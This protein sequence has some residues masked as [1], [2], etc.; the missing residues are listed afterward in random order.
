MNVVV[1]EDAESVE[2]RFCG[3]ELRVAEDGCGREGEGSV[4]EQAAD[5]KV[6]VEV[7][8]GNG[9]FLDAV[10][11][12]ERGGEIAGEEVDRGEDVVGVGVVGI[13][14]EGATEPA[15]CGGI[16]LLL[17]GDSGEFDGKT[18]LRWALAGAGQESGA[19]FNEAV[20]VSES[21]AIGEVQVR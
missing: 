17:K 4:E 21:H 12:L 7:E 3:E 5:A 1:G 11:V 13:E 2:A 8:R 20:E 19:G 14:A 9:R 15:G 6:R 16:L 10:P 18:L